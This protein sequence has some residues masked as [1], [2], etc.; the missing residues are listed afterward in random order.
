[1]AGTERGAERGGVGRGARVRGRRGVGR[2]RAGEVPRAALGER[3]DLW[4]WAG[5]RGGA[6]WGW[7]LWG[8]GFGVGVGG[9]E[10]EEG[11]CAADV[12]DG[13]GE[14]RWVCADA[15]AWAREED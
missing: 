6:C 12:G 14:G 15:W 13:A 9:A 7:V 1:M 8:C 10:C 4:V 11:G 2:V 5:G 3:G